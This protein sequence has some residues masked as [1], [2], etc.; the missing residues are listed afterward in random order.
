MN[1]DYDQMVHVAKATLLAVIATVLLNFQQIRHTFHKS[2]E[3][4]VA[5]QR[6]TNNLNKPAADAPPTKGNK[7][8]KTK[9]T[10]SDTNGEKSNNPEDGTFVIGFFHPH[11]SAGGGGER[12]LW[13]SIQAL[14]ELKEGKLLQ[15]SNNQPR[16]TKT[17]KDIAPSSL[18]NIPEDDNRFVNCKNLSVVIYTVDEPTGTYDTDVMDKVRERFSIVIPSS[19]KIHFVHLHEIKYLLGE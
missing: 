2:R 17:N 8:K 10:K 9:T 15:S 3:D 14:A 4:F 6:Q 16:R 11:C 13:K 5:Y 7:G 18:N 19:L 1:F 12:V